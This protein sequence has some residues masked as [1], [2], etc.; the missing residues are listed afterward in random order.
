MITTRKRLMVDV[1][2]PPKAFEQVAAGKPV[3]FQT[4]VGKQQVFVR[5]RQVDPPGDASKTEGVD[6]GRHSG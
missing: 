4:Q 2:L 6:G 1:P 5:V 3:V